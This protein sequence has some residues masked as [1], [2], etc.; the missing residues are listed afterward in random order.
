MKFPNPILI[1]LFVACQMIA[2]PIMMS[3]QVS[4]HPTGNQADASAILDLTS[5]SR[6]LLIPR[7]STSERD[8]IMLPATGLLI[9]N[10]TTNKFNVYQGTSWIDIATGNLKELLDA[11]GDTK[12]QVEQSADE[13][14]VRFTIAGSERLRLENKY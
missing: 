5:T 9:Y 8:M 4:I 12:V 1:S 13:D 14:K 10:M 3:S 11:D 6:G 7:M 2:F